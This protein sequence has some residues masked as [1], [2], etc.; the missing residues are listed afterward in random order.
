[1][2]DTSRIPT[3]NGRIR[4]LG[5]GV[6]VPVG[7]FHVPENGVKGKESIVTAPTTNTRARRPAGIVT[8]N[9][10]LRTTRINPTM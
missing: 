8:E 1:M 7:L 3:A 6:R 2:A 9:A 4:N 10:F 5:S